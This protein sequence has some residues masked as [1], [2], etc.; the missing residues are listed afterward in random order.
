MPSMKSYPS[1]YNNL[2]S[3]QKQLIFKMVKT[4]EP[5]GASLLLRATQACLSPDNLHEVQIQK[6]T[7]HPLLVLTYHPPL[8]CRKTNYTHKFTQFLINRFTDLVTVLTSSL[9]LIIFYPSIRTSWLL[10]IFWGK[11]GKCIVILQIII[12]KNIPSQFFT[13]HIS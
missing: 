5:V 10:H 6:G 7:P 13:E 4:K 12:E 8:S 2:I 3:Y 9:R 11:G 1:F